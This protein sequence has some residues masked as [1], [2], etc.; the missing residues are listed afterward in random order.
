MLYKDAYDAPYIGPELSRDP[1][2]ALS[3]LEMVKAVAVIRAVLDEFP[4]LLEKI[5][6]IFSEEF[7]NRV[8]GA[9]TVIYQQ[10]LSLVKVKR[11]L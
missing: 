9:V 3:T 4:R 6:T 1:S 11:M 5:S 2:Q 8:L 7:M 10:Q